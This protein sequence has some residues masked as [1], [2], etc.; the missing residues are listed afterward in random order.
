ME[1]NNKSSIV[2]IVYECV[3]CKAHISA[4]QLSITPEIKCPM[5][6]YRVLRKIRPPVVKH[7]KSK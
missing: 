1:E 6:G 4:E 3:D 2:G 7:I 5:C